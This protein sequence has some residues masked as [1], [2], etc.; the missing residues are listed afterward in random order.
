MRFFHKLGFILLTVLGV[1]TTVFAK[2]DLCICQIDTNENEIKYYKAGCVMWN[3]S[4]SCDEKITVSI[5]E[6]LSNILATR[7]HVKSV[8]LGYVGHWGSAEQSAEFIASDV[9]PSI[10]KYGVSFDI[11]NT[12]CLGTDNPYIIRKYL[13]SLDRE[14]AS[15]IHF[16]G[17]QAI[18]TGGWDPALPGKNNFWATIN[19]ESL[20]VGFP[21][22]RE[23]ENIQCFGRFQSGG[24]GICLDHLKKEHAV[25][26]CSENTRKV[27]TSTSNGRSTIYKNQTRHEWVR[28]KIEI[29]TGVSTLAKFRVEGNEGLSHNMVIDPKSVTEFEV[30]EAYFELQM[31]Q[32]K[33]RDWSKEFKRSDLYIEVNTS[34]SERGRVYVEGLGVLER[35]SF[36]E[37]EIAAEEIKKDITHYFMLQADTDVKV[38]DNEEL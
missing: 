14:I 24:T 23:F 13:K 37:A 29:K 9:V 26:K 22:C 30:D 21:K 11:H 38:N 27:K 28:Q 6:D 12:A 1:S 8:K 35:P 20:E 18:S 34:E 10:K 19:G 33:T 15:K 2:N 32:I 17:N 16:N 31:K 3:L 5:K 7:P 25:L 4:Q 36:E